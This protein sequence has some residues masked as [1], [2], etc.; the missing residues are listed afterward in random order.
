MN[1]PYQKNL[2]LHYY[3]THFMEMVQSVTL[4][5]GDFLDD[6]CEQWISSFTAISFEEQC[7]YLRL[8]NRRTTFFEIS[9]VLYKDVGDCHAVLQML[10][11]KAYI[12]R[13]VSGDFPGFWNALTKSD[14]IKFGNF[15]E[16]DWIKASWK[17]DKLIDCLREKNYCSV[18]LTHFVKDYVVL[19]NNDVIT[20]MLFLYSGKV[21][22]R[23]E[24]FTLRDLGVIQVTDTGV[25]QRF[26]DVDEAKE[27]FLYQQIL[28]GLKHN[29]QIDSI[30]LQLNN[31]DT[32][33]SPYGQ[34]LREKALYK[35]ARIFESTHNLGK[36]CVY[37]ARSDYPNSKER[38]VRITHS[39]GDLEKSKALLEQI[40]DNPN[41]DEDLFFATDY[42]ARK[43]NSV[44][45]GYATQMLKSSYCIEI[46]ETYLKA[47]ER[48]V[49]HYLKSE[50]YQAHHTEN[51][52]WLSLFGLVFWEEIHADLH[53]CFDRIPHSLKS[54]SFASLHQDSIKIKCSL[55]AQGEGGPLLLQSHEQHQGKIN[56][57]IRWHKIDTELL[58]KL[59][60]LTG[61]QISKILILMCE[62]H[63]AMR[64]GFPDL[65]AVNDVDVKLLEVKAQG[66]VL[67]KNQMMRLRQLQDAGFNADVIQVK[68][69]Y[70]PEQ[71][72]V[73]VDIETTGGRA[74]S[75]RITEIGAVKVINNQVVDEWHSL[76]NPQRPIPPKITR[77]TG[78]TDSMVRQAPTFAE[79]ANDFAEFLD[80]AVFVAHSVNFDYG[81][82][83]REYERIEC[84]MWM[85]KFCTVVG[86]RRYYK[87][88]TSYGLGNLT[89]EFNI[90]LENHHRAMDDAKATV[91]LLKLI[92]IKRADLD[93]SVQASHNSGKSNVNKSGTTSI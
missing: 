52:L 3:H 50:G 75:H 88:L 72:Y 40:I 91:E 49:I 38:L 55:I 80:G 70:N 46:D 73:V 35:L 51:E 83:R 18:A 79:I 28:T 89:K 12:R 34:E 65:I 27:C 8:L 82:I 66:D 48:G 2:P 90:P 29:D 93:T 64:D 61:L 67:R 14:I 87:G 9:K 30:E 39:S 32:P 78:I 21:Q 33:R 22:D 76:I 7:L 4:N 24:A 6:Q 57:F 42:Y 15:Y 84:R 53:S 31:A 47:P 86:M 56:A 41:S 25:S 19:R 11:H 74:Y 62:N 26:T 16:L 58:V 43:F 45:I 10:E 77:L 63:M 1:N 68:Y 59:L 5:Y 37:F 36:A 54:N 44:K 23:L 81:F 17:K 71:Q 92:N 13:P 85:P 60:A 69:A 20:Y